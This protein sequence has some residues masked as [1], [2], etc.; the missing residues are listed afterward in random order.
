MESAA[1]NISRFLA[2]AFCASK[3]FH[4]S[5]VE[6]V[7]KFKGKLKIGAPLKPVFER[8]A[9]FHRARQ[10]RMIDELKTKQGR[11][12]SAELHKRIIRFPS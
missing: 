8:G 2:S 11:A 12:R 7:N 5:F 6:L 9:G 1:S 10:L 4:R 3:S